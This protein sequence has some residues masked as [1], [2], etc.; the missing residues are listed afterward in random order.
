MVKREGLLHDFST[1]GK[2]DVTA[3]LGVTG[4]GI[5]EDEPI[6]ILTPDFVLWVPNSGCDNGKQETGNGSGFSMSKMSQN[7]REAGE[8]RGRAVWGRDLRHTRS[9]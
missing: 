4:T 6:H 2:L 7:C 1:T 3:A 9:G 5:P 8:A